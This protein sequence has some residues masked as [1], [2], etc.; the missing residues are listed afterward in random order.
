MSSSPMSDGQFARSF[1]TMISLLILLTIALVILAFV[2]TSEVSGRIDAERQVERDRLAAERVQ[3]V[4]SIN[5]GDAPQPA[6]ESAAAA[7]AG[8]PATAVRSG[9]EVYQ[10][11]CLMCHGAGIAGA[12]K[13]GDPA[14]WSDR[15]GAGVDT[16]YD[17]AINGFQG[18]AGVMPAKG[19]NAALSD[20]EVRAAVDYMLGESK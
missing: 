9:N 18:S 16:L 4:A 19:G 14:A 20:D 15:I 11:A 5:V 10:Q 1:F 13:V 8:Q 17:H 2:N 6:A 7:D 3:P 12:P